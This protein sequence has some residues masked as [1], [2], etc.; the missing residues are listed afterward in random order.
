MPPP[1]LPSAQA[2]EIFS[3]KKKK[4]KKKKRKKR[5]KKR[6][7]T[8]AVELTLRVRF[9]AAHPCRIVRTC[10]CAAPRSCK[11][12]LAQHAICWAQS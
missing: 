8:E 12:P 7:K 10:G 3:K 5:K 4:K 6:K 11:E 2:R 1:P 9:G